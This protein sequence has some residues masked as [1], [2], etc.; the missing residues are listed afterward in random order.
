MRMV[1]V[2]AVLKG[3]VETVVIVLAENSDA[4]DL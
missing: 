2:A 1:R 4:D 3:E